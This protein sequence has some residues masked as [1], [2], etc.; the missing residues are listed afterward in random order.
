MDQKKSTLIMNSEPAAFNLELEFE[1]L[2]SSAKPCCGT[3][4]TLPI[5]TCPIRLTDCCHHAEFSDEL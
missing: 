5:C 4:T 2:E 1:D 3:S